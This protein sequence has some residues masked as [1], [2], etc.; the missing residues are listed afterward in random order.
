[1]IALKCNIAVDASC[2]SLRYDLAEMI[3]QILLEHVCP[4][5][6]TSCAWNVWHL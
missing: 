4:I 1:M 2:L 5:R 3:Q 6:I